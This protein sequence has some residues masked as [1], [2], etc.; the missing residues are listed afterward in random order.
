MA[1]ERHV[2]KCVA[3]NF[4]IQPVTS[5]VEEPFGSPRSEDAQA[6]GST[7]CFSKHAR[8]AAECSTHSSASTGTAASGAF[9]VTEGVGEGNNEQRQAVD[10][11]TETGQQ[12]H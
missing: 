8:A 6:T 9:H 11:A 12:D 5:E 4:G 10:R 3:F 2:V 7:S 1:P